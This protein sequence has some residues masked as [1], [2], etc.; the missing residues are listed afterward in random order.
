MAP[1]AHLAV[2]VVL[3]ALVAARAPAAR[4]PGSRRD[5]WVGQ[6]AIAVAQSL[7]IPAVHAAVD[8][9]LGPAGTATATRGWT[10]VAGASAAL[11]FSGTSNRSRARRHAI[12]V[13]AVATMGVVAATFAATR[14]TDAVDALSRVPDGA[15]LTLVTELHWAT[16][17]AFMCW[18][19][20]GSTVQC[21]RYGPRASGPLRPELLLVGGGCTIGVVYLSFKAACPA[22]SGRGLPG[23][24]GR[25]PSAGRGRTPRSGRAA[26]RRRRQRPDCDADHAP[27]TTGGRGAAIAA[28]A[29]S[30]MAAGRGRGSPHR[31]RARRQR[32]CSRHSWGRAPASC[33]A[34]GRDS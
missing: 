4:L 3:W 7:Q 25:A 13:V 28:A 22:A 18:A 2:S 20:S 8:G 5:L 14:P 27:G 29:L 26:D 24:A 12:V 31:A 6:L 10:V 1:S 9:L 19:L 11:L 30:A 16:Y 34:C 33:Q 21:W 17:L 32:A 15:E 23:R